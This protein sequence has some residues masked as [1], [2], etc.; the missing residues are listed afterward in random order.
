MGLKTE[1]LWKPKYFLNWA[2][3]LIECLTT[4]F[5]MNWREGSGSEDPRN[6]RVDKLSS[7]CSLVV[8]LLLN[9]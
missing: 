1:K 8:R 3:I 9:C 6:A 5:L 7:E 4:G 2:H